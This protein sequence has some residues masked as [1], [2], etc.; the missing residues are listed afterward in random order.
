VNFGAHACTKVVPKAGYKEA[1]HA[2]RKRFAG[3]VS[4]ATNTCLSKE[5]SA[6]CLAMQCHCGLVYVTFVHPS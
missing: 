6:W 3:N 1:K 5:E 2:V 4:E